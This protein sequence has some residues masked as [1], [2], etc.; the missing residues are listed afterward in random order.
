MLQSA[1]DGSTIGLLEK[2]AIFGERRNEVLSG[3]IANI[4]TPGYKTR[5]LPVAKFQQALAE[6][7]ENRKPDPS[8][9]YNTYAPV[10]DKKSLSKFFPKELFQAIEAPAKNITFQDGNNRSIES[11]MMEK[12]KNTM[13]QRFAVELMSAQMNL[14]QAVIS[15]RA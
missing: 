10:G 14:L 15:V 4:D 11:E 8:L 13:M 6:A 5:D 12:Q 2:M 1:F 3:N 9:G 7:I